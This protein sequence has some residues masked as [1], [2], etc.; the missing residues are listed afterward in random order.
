MKKAGTVILIFAVLFCACGKAAEPFEP[1]RSFEAAFEL[2]SGEIPIAGTLRVYA[3]DDMRISFTS[4][5]ALV[6]CTLLLTPEGCRMEVGELQDETAYWE[7][8]EDAP[9]KLLGEALRASVFEK[10]SFTQDKNG[11]YAVRLSLS[12]GEADVAFAPDGTLLSIRTDAGLTVDF[13]AVAVK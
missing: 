10:Q 11:N 3:Y 1:I 12:G 13:T 7:L 4:P 2:K 9:V 5:E 8:P 6:S